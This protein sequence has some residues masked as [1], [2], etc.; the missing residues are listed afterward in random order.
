MLLICLSGFCGQQAASQGLIQD[1]QVMWM[2]WNEIT[3]RSSA[4]SIA[5][6]CPT[7]PDCAGQRVRP[8]PQQI[9]LDLGFD[10]E[11][12]DTLLDHIERSLTRYRYSIRDTTDEICHGR[13]EI[14]RLE[15]LYWLERNAKEQLE[16]E[17][18]QYLDEFRD[19]LDEEGNRRVSRLPRE[20]MGSMTYGAV[21]GSS[22]VID[23]F[24]FGWRDLYSERSATAEARELQK[25]LF[26]KCGAE[27]VFSVELPPV[28]EP[29]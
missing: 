4:Q 6:G 5:L 1:D 10:R 7:S 9:F 29:F 27:L 23:A 21:R 19:L 17:R 24:E 11:A 25:R 28:L 26:A 8:Q 13:K 2:S 14:V 20:A 12:A 3:G 18:Q 16:L 15:Q 22:F